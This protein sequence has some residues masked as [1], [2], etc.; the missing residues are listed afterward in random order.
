[1][2]IEMTFKEIEAAALSAPWGSDAIAREIFHLV[3]EA[4]D[5]AVT[6]IYE[7]KSAS[8]DCEE[9]LAMSSLEGLLCSYSGPKE[10]L[11]W[12]KTCGVRW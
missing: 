11:N 2:E 8:P 7:E 3:G 1:M 12:F 9:R 5:N 10:V 4:R 6:T